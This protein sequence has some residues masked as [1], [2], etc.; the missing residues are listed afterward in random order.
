MTKIFILS[1]FL[2]CM[3]FYSYAQSA[4]GVASKP[5]I[6]LIPSDEWLYNNN[7]VIKGDTTLS[8]E[9]IPD[10]RKA[11]LA[12]KGISSVLTALSAMFQKEDF[13]TKDLNAEL[14]RLNTE[15][16]RRGVDAQDKGGIKTSEKAQLLRG[17]QAD[18]YIEVSYS[19]ERV[20]LGKAIHVNLNAMDSYSNQRVSSTQGTGAPSSCTDFPTMVYASVANVLP[21]FSQEIRDYFMDIVNNGRY[22]SLIFEHTGDCDIDFNSKF[23]E[24]SLDR[25]IDD[26]IIDNSNDA[27][28]QYSDENGM[29]YTNIRVPMVTATGRKQDIKYWLR[30]IEDTFE[31]LGI[32]Y[33][34]TVVGSGRA[35]VTITGT[36]N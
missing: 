11:L 26:W 27:S 10:Y 36:D 2:A 8:D 14:K 4:Q 22:Y 6:I 20:G 29:E 34:I 31:Q 32:G 15:Q 16:M 9:F 1:F 3:T 12:D 19:I 5:T 33:D 18:L 30:S 25:I 35:I 7:Y 28:Q 13:Y 21:N 17:A 24:K 23:N